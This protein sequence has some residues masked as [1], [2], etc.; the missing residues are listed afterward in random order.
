MFGKKSNAPEEKLGGVNIQ[1]IPA[2]FYGGVDPVVKFKEVSKEIQSGDAPAGGLSSKERQILN[3]VRVAGS[4]NRLHPINLFNNRKFLIIGAVVL[5]VVFA[6]GATWYYW[7]DVSNNNQTPAISPA[8]SLQTP[9]EPTVESL[10]TE[11]TFA[12]TTTPEPELAPTVESAEEVASRVSA[13]M[14]F[15]SKFSGD[16]SDLDNDGLTDKEE[17]VFGTDPGVPDTDG[18]NYMDGLEVKNLYNPTGFKPV[19]ILDSG[20]VADY[21]DTYFGYSVYY[22]RDWTVGDVGKDLR[23]LL[24]TAP[25]G[26]FV[27]IRVFDKAP[28]QSFGDWFTENAVGQ[29][30]G[31]LKDFGN[32]F[33]VNSHQ[34]TDRL[35]YFFENSNR[36][37]ALVYHE[38]EPDV[39]NYRNVLEMMAQSWRFSATTEILQS[40]IVEGQTEETTTTL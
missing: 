21:T 22:P 6:A 25:T 35:V 19:K 2:D 5:F 11:E 7:P 15:P 37:Y 4:G 30:F 18:D 17:E 16:S 24:F 13:E 10:A 34:R 38:S 40:P 31:D 20:M 8:V 9:P 23:D 3:S 39:I 33:K 28:N 1:T 27:E 29:S 36:V 12:P 32:R 14:E 26:E